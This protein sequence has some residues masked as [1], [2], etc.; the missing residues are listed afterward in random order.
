MSNTNAIGY[1]VM[2]KSRSL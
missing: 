1:N 2:L